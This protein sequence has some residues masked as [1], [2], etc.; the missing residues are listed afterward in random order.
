MSKH[1][2]MTKAEE[3]EV[4]QRGIKFGRLQ[5]LIAVANAIDAVLEQ[6]WDIDE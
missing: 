3:R 6:D 5:A 4:L 2:H 1:R